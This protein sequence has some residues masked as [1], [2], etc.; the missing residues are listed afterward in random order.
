MA[1]YSGNIRTSIL[2]PRLDKSNKIASFSLDSV[3]SVY[4]SNMRLMNIG[5]TATGA[6]YNAATGA[7]ETIERLT[8]F[9]GNTQLAQQIQFPR[10]AAFKN[11]HKSNEANR[12]IN[13]FLNGSGMGYEVKDL[14]VSGNQSAN[15]EPARVVKGFTADDA[16][17]FKSW[18]D[19]KMFLPLLQAVPFLPTKVFKNLRLEIE[20][21]SAVGTAQNTTAPILVVDEIMDNETRNSLEKQLTQVDFVQVEHDMIVVD[22]VSDLSANKLTN[23]QSIQKQVKGF[24]N[25]VLNRLLVV[26]Q[27][28]GATA[29]LSTK[30]G[31]LTSYLQHNEKDN[32]RVNGRTLLV[33]D[34]L[35]TT[36]KSSAMLSDVWGTCNMFL[37]RLALDDNADG[38]K[39]LGTAADDYLGSQDY[40]CFRV[41]QRIEQ[42][43]YV[44][45]RT[46]CFDA[47]A[48]GA[49]TTLPINSQLV[50]H[51]FGEVPKRLQ[52][53]SD[54]TYLIAYL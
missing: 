51:Y 8:L 5:V 44:F 3:D 7:Y 10:W 31:Q 40:R 43:E 9:D 24:D 48:A 32:L 12:S 34:G 41:G 47:A 33:G 1:F 4:L 18:I 35:D 22:A 52:V 49:Q 26:K 29:G 27:P 6:D 42:M 15:I 46:G 17:T 21:N 19:L 36:A 53:N 37:N 39:V 25:K 28:Q 38:T 23:V 11:Y 50:L 54:G 2:D 30:M 16:T 20:Y 45:E 14:D 13:H